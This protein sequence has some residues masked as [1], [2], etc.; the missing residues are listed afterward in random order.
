MTQ[1]LDLYAESFGRAAA[2]DFK[3]DVIYWSAFKLIYWSYKLI[4]INFW[5]DHWLS[6]EVKPDVIYW[7]S[8]TY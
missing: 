2:L 4:H 8:D 6:T 7:S 1:R 3:P 5:C